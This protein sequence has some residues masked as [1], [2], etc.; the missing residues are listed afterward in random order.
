MAESRLNRWK[1][2]GPVVTSLSGCYFLTSVVL[3]ENSIHSRGLG[4][5]VLWWEDWSDLVM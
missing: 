5:W 1:A 2:Q 4:T 3:V